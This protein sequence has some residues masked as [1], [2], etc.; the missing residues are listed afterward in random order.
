MSRP[1]FVIG[2]KKARNPRPQNKDERVSPHSLQPTTCPDGPEVAN[3]RRARASTVHL[4][5]PLMPKKEERAAACHLQMEIKREAVQFRF[6]GQSG[7]EYRLSRASHFGQVARGRHAPSVEKR[8]ERG[9]TIFLRFLVSKMPW[10]PE[11]VRET[12]MPLCLRRPA[13]FGSCCF[14]LDGFG[15]MARYE[16]CRWGLR[17]R[18]AARG[19]L[20]NCAVMRAPGKGSSHRRFLKSCAEYPDDMQMSSGLFIA[21][22]PVHELPLRFLLAVL[23]DL[24]EDVDRCIEHEDHQAKPFIS[25]HELPLRFLLEVLLDLEEDVDRCTEHDG[26]EEHDGHQGEQIGQEDQVGLKHFSL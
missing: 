11:A 16:G 19:I 10:S 14:N 22:C 8:G 6:A 17:S 24:E 20:A 2:A 3:D 5:A 9:L 15:Q 4:R 12:H 7:A 13:M 1:L 26:D 18:R 25:V 23:L 21:V